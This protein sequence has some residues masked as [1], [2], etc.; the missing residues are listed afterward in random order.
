MVLFH[1]LGLYIVLK[2]EGRW[3]SKIYLG[4]RTLGDQRFTPSTMSPQ[5]GFNISN[6][7][8]ASLSPELDWQN[9]GT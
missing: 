6:F 4:R 1:W 2:S 7:C 8:Q 3:S 9:K 5:C